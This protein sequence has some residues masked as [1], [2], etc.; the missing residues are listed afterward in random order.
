M[1]YF[2]IASSPSR[3]SS[4]CSCT[5]WPPAPSPGTCSASSAWTWA[6]KS[7]SSSLKTPEAPAVRFP[8]RHR[9]TIVKTVAVSANRSRILPAANS[10]LI[11]SSMVSWLRD[12]EEELLEK[13]ALAPAIGDVSS[14]HDCLFTCFVFYQR[15]ACVNMPFQPN[16]V[17]MQTF[18]L[19]LFFGGLFVVLRKFV[20]FF[21][22]SGRFQVFW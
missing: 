10:F 22:I 17:L 3:L 15:K 16:L 18:L 19:L 21:I 1:S 7:A 5:G 8:P 2:F 20:G 14:R 9:S 12:Y 13:R 4:P 6:S 11:G